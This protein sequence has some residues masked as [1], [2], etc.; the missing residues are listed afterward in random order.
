MGRRQGKKDLAGDY[1]KLAVLIQKVF[2]PSDA[3]TEILALNRIVSS[4]VLS[5]EIRETGGR[6]GTDRDPATRFEASCRMLASIRGQLGSVGDRRVRLA[7]LDA[8]LTLEQD[9]FLTGTILMDRLPRASRKERLEWLKACAN[10][11]YGMGLISGRQ[12]ESLLDTFQGI[13]GPSVRWDDYRAGLNYAARVPGWADQNLR[14]H[15]TSAVDTLLVLEPLTS[16]Y[17]SDRVRGSLL[18][19]YSSVLEGL[20]A[21]ANRQFGIANR[22]MDRS[23][24]CRAHRFESRDCPWSAQSGQGR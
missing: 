4:K 1:E 24:G 6:L 22:M 12:R 9:L 3:R 23:S 17:L 20:L 21:D 18:I 11:L 15:F 5:Q 16:T 2:Q 8:S 7:L 19:V 10:G 14:F 13:S